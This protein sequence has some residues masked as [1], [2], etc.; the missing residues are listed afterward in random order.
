MLTTAKINGTGRAD[1]CHNF[2]TF[3]NVN[4]QPRSTKVK[5]LTLWTTKSLSR[6]ESEVHPICLKQKSIKRATKSWNK[7][8]KRKQKLPRPNSTSEFNCKTTR[9][10][11]SCKSWGSNS[12]QNNNKNH[13]HKN[14]PKSR[15]SKTSWSLC[16]RRRW[17]SITWSKRPS[18]KTIKLKSS[19]TQS[20]HC[21]RTIT[22]WRCSITQGSPQT[23]RKSINWKNKYTSWKW[24]FNREKLNLQES[25]SRKLNWSIKGIRKLLL[26]TNLLKGKDTLLR[27]WKGPRKTRSLSLRRFY[28]TRELSWIRKSMTKRT[29]A[30]ESNWISQSLKT[31][32]RK[33]LH[34][35]K[36]PD[37]TSTRSST[38][39]RSSSNR[40]NQW[41]LNWKSLRSIN[42]NSLSFPES[43]S[44]FLMTRSIC[45]NNWKRP[46][47][48]NKSTS[49]SWPNNTTPRSTTIRSWTKK[50]RIRPS[51]KAPES[52]SLKAN[53]KWPR[54][55]SKSWRE[56]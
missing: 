50:W 53:W 8:T 35:C 2:P 47:N 5:T 33:F 55:N 43:S 49:V 38:I 12:R 34:N 30:P 54:T 42:K 13:W 29:N 36:N 31:S 21:R 11:T 45:K 46:S 4:L 9:T 3:P 24:D 28:K 44:S 20:A 10:I 39:R 37:C 48:Q 51:N 32:S 18:T 27:I 7:N 52:S 16:R 19:K 6:E 40:E 15:N 25:S 1:K 41:N 26:K 23:N 17:T 14:L 22:N 56:T